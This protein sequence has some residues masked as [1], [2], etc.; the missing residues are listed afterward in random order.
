MVDDVVQGRSGLIICY[1]QSFSGKR[2]T[3]FGDGRWLRGLLADRL[4]RAPDLEGLLPR[5][6]DCIADCIAATSGAT[7]V[8]SVSFLEVVQDMA[9]DLLDGVD[10]P[11]RQCRVRR[12]TEGAPYAEGLSSREV[13]C[14]DDMRAALADG[15]ARHVGWVMHMGGSDTTRSHMLFTITVDVHEVSSDGSR[16]RRSATLRFAKLAGSERPPKTPGALGALSLHEYSAAHPS[17]ADFM[18]VLRAL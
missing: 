11:M 12:T 3:V 2:H 13:R 8:V 5:S 4:L 18:T 10:G 6:F 1:G 15:W 7:V 14:V 16:S 17:C 9:Y